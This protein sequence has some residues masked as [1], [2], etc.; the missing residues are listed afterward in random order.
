[1]TIVRSPLGVELTEGRYGWEL[2]VPEGDGGGTFTHLTS[3]ILSGYELGF[4]AATVNPWSS[5]GAT[6]R[7]RDMLP[8]EVP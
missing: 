5:R 8:Y 1:V 6:F 4:T 7:A 3:D 2:V